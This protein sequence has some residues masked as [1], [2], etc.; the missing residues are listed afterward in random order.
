MPKINSWTKAPDIE[1][2]GRKMNATA[3]PDLASRTPNIAISASD[4]KIK[5]LPAIFM[6]ISILFQPACIASPTAATLV[7][8]AV[9]EAWKA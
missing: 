9:G 7:I 2:S 8:A 3:S 4:A 6:T 5:M 1:R